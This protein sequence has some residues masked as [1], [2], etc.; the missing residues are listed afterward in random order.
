M[1]KLILNTFFIVYLFILF[2]IFFI[3][4]SEKW[5]YY[6]NI[7]KKTIIENDHFLRVPCLLSPEDC[8]RHISLLLWSAFISF[9]RSDHG[10]LNKLFLLH[11]WSSRLL[12]SSIFFFFV[13]ILSSMPLHYSKIIQYI[14]NKIKIVKSIFFVHFIQTLYKFFF[15]FSSIIFI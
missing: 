5:K 1:F 8:V 14:L 3:I 12:V 9:L 11:W 4:K 6:I 7:V 13:S 2:I 10:I 15:N